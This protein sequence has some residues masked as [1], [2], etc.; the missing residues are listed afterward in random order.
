M[1]NSYVSYLIILLLAGSLILDV[2]PVLAQVNDGPFQVY[3][4]VY[5]LRT[6]QE[7]ESGTDEHGWRVQSRF[8]A[9]ASGY[10]SVGFGWDC[11]C[12]GS[13]GA[14]AYLMNNVTAGG[15]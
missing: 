12:C 4:H 3:N 13:V 15:A 5:Q 6:G 8:D 9:P 11:N 2:M 7:D 1:R 14:N 10:Y